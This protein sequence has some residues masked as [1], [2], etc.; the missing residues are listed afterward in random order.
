MPLSCFLL[1]TCLLGLDLRQQIFTASIIW[2]NF[3]PTKLTP[4]VL[5][6]VQLV[7]VNIQLLQKSQNNYYVA[8]FFTKQHHCSGNG[9]NRK[10]QKAGGNLC[11]FTQKDILNVDK[12]HLELGCQT[13]SGKQLSRQLTTGKEHIETKRDFTLA[14]RQTVRNFSKL[15][16]PTGRFPWRVPTQ[17]FKWERIMFGI[18][19]LRKLPSY[20]H[21]GSRCL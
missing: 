15:K 1:A 11:G 8:P 13:L 18:A 20:I 14:V 5:E 3:L 4:E 6:N 7:P 12:F 9:M 17:Q 21:P 2:K 10:V 16:V 19:R